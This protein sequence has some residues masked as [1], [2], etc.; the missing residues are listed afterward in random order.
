MKKLLLLFCIIFLFGIK[1]VNAETLTITFDA[2][3]GSGRTKVVEYEKGPSYKMLGADSFKYLDD[4]LDN[5]M[6]DKV[7]SGWSKNPDGAITYGAYNNITKP[8]YELSGTTPYDVLNN[9]NEITLYGVWTKRQDV[10]YMIDSFTV[11]GEGVTQKENG[12]YN[13]PLDSSVEFKFVLKESA[14]SGGLSH[15]LSELS[16]FDLPD[17]LLEYFPDYALKAFSIPKSIPIRITYSGNEYPTE[18]AKKYIKNHKLFI[19]IIP[20]GSYGASLVESS[21]NITLKFSFYGRVKKIENNGHIIRGVMISYE[22]PDDTVE[23]DYIF[24]QG[25]IVSKYIDIET[26]KELIKDEISEDIIWTKYVLN[27]KNIDDYKLI[28][29]PEED[30]YYLED[31]QQTIY[32]KYRKINNSP[33]SELIDNPNTIRFITIIVLLLI[34]NIAS[35]YIYMI[36]RKDLNN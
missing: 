6:D 16:Y 25:K 28:E 27:E 13:I 18:H 34:I 22:I 9:A 11:M 14:P 30:V 32:Y 23:K 15:Q 26:G 4:N 21:T 1:N 17:S 24:P 29:Y 19:D 35:L 8:N 3:D 7:I 10:S 5:P 20:D 31:K 12:D 36:K 2:N 33:S